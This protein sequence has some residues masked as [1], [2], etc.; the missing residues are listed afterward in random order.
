MVRIKFG[1]SC[2]GVKE[3]LSKRLTIN[4]WR[5]SQRS[6]LRNTLYKATL[7]G[8]EEVTL[9][10]KVGRNS[11]TLTGILY[12]ALRFANSWPVMVE[13]DSSG[14]SPL[15]LGEGRATAE[16]SLMGA[17]LATNRWDIGARS[18]EELEE[19]QGREGVGEDRN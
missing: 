16:R 18:S 19:D 14:V 1:T 4:G 8:Q 9:S 3:Y 15:T 12:W 7:P 10:S 17:R 11:W 5:S 2:A 6:A 13:L